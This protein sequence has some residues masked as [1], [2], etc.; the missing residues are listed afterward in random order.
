[1]N[2]IYFILQWASELACH[3]LTI[4]NDE[5]T[6]R[7]EFQTQ[8]EGHFLNSLFPGM[9]D[10]PPSF[11]TQAPSIFDSKLPKITTDDVERLKTQ[12][13]D[14]TKSISVPDMSGIT[15]FFFVKSQVKEDKN[16]E[17]NVEEKLVQ[18]VSDVGLASNLDKGLL[19][20]VDSEPFLS[21]HAAIP[22]LKDLDK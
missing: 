14:L 8:F 15:Q 9:E 22:H 17:R 20:P 6:R 7:K 3:I 19:K 13:P 11:A 4:H 18:A 12:L 5:V 21:A 16:D 1:M 2:E 10:L